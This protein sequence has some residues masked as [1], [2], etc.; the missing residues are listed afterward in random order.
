MMYAFARSLALLVVAII[1]LF[2][3]STAFV[4]AVAIAMVV[5]QAADAIIGV[6]TRDTLKTVGP[7]VTAVAN[8]GVLIWM[9]AA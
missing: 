1:A 4:A 2:A 6:R 9:L 5:V 3:G 8:L 7:A